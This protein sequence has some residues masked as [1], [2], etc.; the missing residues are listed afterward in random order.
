MSHFNQ[1]TKRVTVAGGGGSTRVWDSPCGAPFKNLSIIV[2]GEGFNVANVTEQVFLGGYF[3]DGSSVVVAPYT[4]GS[5]H[6][7]G[8]SQGAAAA[9]GTGTVAAHAIYTNTAVLPANNPD[10]NV[11]MPVVVEFANTNAGAVSFDVTF[12]SE[13]LSSTV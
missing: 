12:V 7:G 6:T 5:T 1:T 9:I 13:T 3:V 2:T 8:V 4:E 11:L 10:R